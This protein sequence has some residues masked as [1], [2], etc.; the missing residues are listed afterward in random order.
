LLF[1]DLYFLKWRQIIAIKPRKL[2][3]LDVFIDLSKCQT[4]LSMSHNEIILVNSLGRVELFLKLL[5]HNSLFFILENI[6]FQQV[7]PNLD[8]QIGW[9]AFRD[10]VIGIS[11][12][13][14]RLIMPYAAE[15]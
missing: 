14:V 9:Y 13:L 1:K 8:P 15:H 5:S 12:G 2:I 11:I 10:Q 6:N 7:P 4:I 3:A